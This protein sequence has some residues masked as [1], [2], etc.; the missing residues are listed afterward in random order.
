MLSTVITDVVI[1]TTLAFITNNLQL[2]YSIMCCLELVVVF[3][4]LNTIMIN[5]APLLYVSI[6][7]YIDYINTVHYYCH[8]IV[9]VIPVDILLLVLA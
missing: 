8:Y 2:H 1:I 9:M 7:G 4:R 3:Q 5:T 6:V